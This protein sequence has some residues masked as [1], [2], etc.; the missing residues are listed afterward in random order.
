M[1]LAILQW[2][3]RAYFVRDSELAGETGL[4]PSTVLHILKDSLRT[5]KTSSKWVPHN[6]TKLQIWLWYNVA[7]TPAAALL[8]DN[9]RRAK[10]E[11]WLIW[12]VGLASSLPYSQDL[13]SYDFDLISKMKEPVGGSRFRIIHHILNTVHRSLWTINRLGSANGI[14]RFLHHIVGS[15]AEA[16]KTYSCGSMLYL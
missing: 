10:Q 14:R 15:D 4:E 5:R 2:R 8:N 9:A 7:L 12:I 13:S 3:W 1:C 16:C 11:L 6:L